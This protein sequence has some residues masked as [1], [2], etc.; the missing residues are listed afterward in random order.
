MKYSYRCDEHGT[1]TI[2]RSIK[3]TPTKLEACP[4][5]QADS[6]RDFRAD[7]NPVIYN[8]EGFSKDYFDKPVGRGQP[9]HKKEWL[10]SNWSR[11]YGEAPP[12]EDSKGTY[13]G[14]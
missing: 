9:M 8:G 2:S 1:F 12:K 14:T 6:T 3:D 13:D 10:N 5:C 11:H 7:L 4:L